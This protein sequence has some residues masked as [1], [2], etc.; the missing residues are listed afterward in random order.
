[1]RRPR[2]RGGPRL[3]RTRADADVAARS[4]ECRREPGTWRRGGT[5]LGATAPGPAVAPR[6]SSRPQLP[7]NEHETTSVV[8]SWCARQ[9][10]DQAEA[11]GEH[12]LANGRSTRY[13]MWAACGCS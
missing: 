4:P 11:E 7:A 8:T 6:P 10:A 9:A 5:P 1:S 12:P 2:R 3:G 13:I